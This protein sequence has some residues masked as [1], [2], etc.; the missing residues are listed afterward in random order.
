MY[1]IPMILEMLGIEGLTILCAQ[2]V[3][4]TLPIEILSTF[5]KLRFNNYILYHFENGPVS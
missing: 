2:K 5:Y 3:Q 1:K 4:A